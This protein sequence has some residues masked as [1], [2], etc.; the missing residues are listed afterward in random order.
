[1]S[2]ATPTSVESLIECFPTPMTRVRGVP[3]FDDVYR[4]KQELQ[5][6]SASVQSN[7]GGGSHGYLGIIIN[8]PNQYG[9]IAHN[10][11]NP[12]VAHVFTVPTYP[13]AHAVM[14]GGTNEQR[15]AQLQTYKENMF[16]W[17]SYDNMVKALR[18]VLT[19]AYDDV[20]LSPLKNK[21]TGYNN[22]SVPN[23]LA[24]PFTEYGEITASDLKA[25]E[26]RMQAEW[27]GV[28]PYE[29]IINRFDDCILTSPVKPIAPLPHR[30][31]CTKPNWSSTTQDCLATK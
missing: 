23:I 14:D 1:M 6:N 30:K 2:G 21:I 20:Y 29:S 19:S 10:G 25:N 24:H 27:D 12:P 8:N 4:T 18:K 28:T 3:T 13:G 16:E 7:L 9:L 15:A 5:S 17:R 22:V 31:S 11:A 26:E